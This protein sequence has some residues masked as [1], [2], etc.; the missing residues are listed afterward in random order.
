MNII[1]FLSLSL[2]LFVRSLRMFLLFRILFYMAYHPSPSLSCVLNWDDFH[3]LP[4]VSSRNLI[5]DSIWAKPIVRSIEDQPF[6]SKTRAASTERWIHRRYALI[7]QNLEGFLEREE[8]KKNTK[9]K[10]RTTTTTTTTWLR[11]LLTVNT[12]T[13]NLLGRFFLCSV[14]LLLWD[15]SN[16]L[17]L[18]KYGQISDHPGTE[19]IRHQ[20]LPG[21]RI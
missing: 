8:R 3:S 5:W 4:V 15:I 14:L 16:E 9:K 13:P 7:W 11:L 17:V 12:N 10:R 21:S 6:S 19:A 20:P 2:S 1:F 18:L